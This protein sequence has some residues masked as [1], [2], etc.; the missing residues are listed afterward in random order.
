MIKFVRVKSPLNSGKTLT[1][2]M[3]WPN[4]PMLWSASRAPTQNYQGLPCGIGPVSQETDYQYQYEPSSGPHRHKHRK[5]RHKMTE[6]RYH[7]QFEHVSSGTITRDC[8]TGIHL[9][10][11]QMDVS[12]KTRA[13]GA[14]SPPSGNPSMISRNTR[15]QD[16]RVTPYKKTYTFIELFRLVVPPL[17]C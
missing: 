2:S 3:G 6:A 11:D 4:Y 8:R 7:N 10:M 9:G 12:N 16:V 15:S 17:L 1:S 13:G 5:G 14:W